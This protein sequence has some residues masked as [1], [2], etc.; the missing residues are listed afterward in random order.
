MQFLSKAAVFLLLSAVI[1][2]PLTAQGIYASVGAQERPAGCHEDSGNVPAPGPTSHSCCQGAHHPAI[3]Q[4]RSVS[5]PS[6]QASAPVKDWYHAVVSAALS[7]LVNLVIKC[8][9][10][11]LASPLRV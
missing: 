3:L 9:D 4:Q 5:R 1:A 6:L 8:G 2:A 11:P 7:M 10:P